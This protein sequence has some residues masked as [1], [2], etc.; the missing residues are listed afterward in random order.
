M[1]DETVIIDT[2]VQE[3]LS[4]NIKYEGAMSLKTSGVA[5]SQWLRNVC[6]SGQTVY[7]GGGYSM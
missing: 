3:K 5:P 2:F 6:R 4:G 1:N 7:V